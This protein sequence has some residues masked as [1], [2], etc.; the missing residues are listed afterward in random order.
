MEFIVSTSDLLSQLNIIKGVINSKNTLPI[1]DNFLFQLEG[2]TLKITASDLET[3]LNTQIELN[4]A[5]GEGIIA[6]DAKRLTDLL[7]EFTDQPL[8]FKVNQETFQ[9]DIQSASGKFAIVGQNGDEFPKV[10]E[11]DASK[12]SIT[13]GSDVFQKAITSTI[14]ATGD[15][16]M[17]PVM[18]G[19]YFELTQDHFRLV[20]TDSHKLAR[21]TRT[22]V[23][24][25]LDANFILPKKTANILKNILAKDGNN[26]TVE[27]DGKNAFF[28]LTDYRIVCRLIEG[29]YPAYS[30]V[31]PTENPNKL[32]V[33]RMDLY[34]KLKVVSLFANPASNLTKLE[35]GGAM[36]TISAQDIDFSTS[37]QEQLNCRY[38]G[39]E[40][41]IGFKSK[42]LL[43]ILQ[44]INSVDVSVELSDPSRAGII[45]PIDKDEEAE[46]ILMLL[47]PMMV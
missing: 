30:A 16:E 27:F 24:A 11:L 25:D 22:D 6:L 38:E 5:K 39:E 33:D 29:K 12:S 45:I 1:L 36:L 23:K 9:I 15:D 20:A 7:K 18:N 10:P 31:I 21:Y 40:L 43:D 37:G 42:F 32:L 26:I 4:N 34:N 17:R 46:D 13:L 35:M 3:T 19:I 41:T 14:F 8:T 44:N 28:T 47:M 2:N